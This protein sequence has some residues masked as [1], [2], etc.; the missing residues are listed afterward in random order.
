MGGDW[1][2]GDLLCARRSEIRRPKSEIGTPAGAEDAIGL[3]QP[4]R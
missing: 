1:W 4:I 2:N 3:G